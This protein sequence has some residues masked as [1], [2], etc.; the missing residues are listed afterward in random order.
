MDH[1]KRLAEL[2]KESLQKFEEYLTTKA[3]LK[4]EDHEKLALAKD[5]WQLAWNKFLE[6]LMVLER[7]EI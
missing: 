3:S 6:T 2:N 7:I 1:K 5:E 4:K